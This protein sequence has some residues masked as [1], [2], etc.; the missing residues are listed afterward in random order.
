MNCTICGR[1]LAD[2]DKFCIGCGTA[3]QRPPQAYAPQPQ[4]EYASPPSQA[5]APPPQQEYAPPPEPQAYAP[6][7]QQAYVPPP[8]QQ[9]Y[10]P[11]PTTQPNYQQQFTG[12]YGD[13][14]VATK[15][16]I[17]SKTIIII[18]AV[19]AVAALALIL[20]LT[21]GGGGGGYNTPEAL[22]EDYFNAFSSSDRNKIYNMFLPEL[23]DL[24]GRM[25]EGGRDAFLAEHDDWLS[26]YGDRIIDKTMGERRTLSQSDMQP[27]AAVLGVTITEGINIRVTAESARYTYTIDFTMVRVGGKWY[28]V[29]I[30]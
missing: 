23:R 19:V 2:S 9:A 26:D 1:L 27:Q 4:Q 15:K 28:A 10:A 16:T 20:I 11:P 7:L 5:Y 29:D 12:A 17:S 24:W 18:V 6:P 3:V 25:G 22:I 14:S 13:T 30:W 21:L 8:P